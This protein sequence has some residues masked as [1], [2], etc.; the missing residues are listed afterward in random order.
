[1]D[2]SVMY[3]KLADLESGK[4]LEIGA[5]ETKQLAQFLIQGM[6]ADDA[7]HFTNHLAGTV[8]S[9]I[10]KSVSAE[11]RRKVGGAR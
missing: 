9:E 1:M 2:C 5:D 7:M 6:G 10:I 11:M 4:R 3:A 8:A